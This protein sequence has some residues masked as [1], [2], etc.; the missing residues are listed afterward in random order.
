MPVLQQALAILVSSYDALGMTALRDDT[1][2]V[3]EK[4][5][6]QSDFLKAEGPKKSSS[7]W[8]LW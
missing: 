1:K 4:N 3:L 6:P 8:R 2:R 5:F 7:W